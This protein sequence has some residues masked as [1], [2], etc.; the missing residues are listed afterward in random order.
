VLNQTPR[1]CSSVQ[2]RNQFL[3]V[4]SVLENWCF[5][6]NGVI[7]SLR[8]W[9]AETARPQKPHCLPALAH[10]PPMLA[11]VMSAALFAIAVGAATADV[12]GIAA[13]PVGLEANAGW[14]DKTIVMIK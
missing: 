14:R 8:S 4:S 9:V 6:E 2:P 10:D 3:S 11:R 1:F 13:F 7:F 12:N 5:P